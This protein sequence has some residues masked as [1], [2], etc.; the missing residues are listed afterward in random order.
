MGND[1]IRRFGL[2]GI[3]LVVVSML[4]VNVSAGVSFPNMIE[5]FP[6][7]SV[8]RTVILQNG[9]EGDGDVK[10]VMSISEGNEFVSVVDESEVVVSKGEPGYLPIRI[11]LPEG[12][13]VGDVHKVKLDFKAV[14]DATSEGSGNAVQFNVGYGMNFDIVSVPMVVEEVAP[15]SATTETPRKSSASEM[16]IW[17]I[18]VI[19]AFLISLWV[20]N[21][22]SGRRN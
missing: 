12:T 8:E 5:L 11:S 14:S 15:I 9:P 22:R 20:L 16:V 17:I 7:E 10:F 18:A 1:V 13:S 19:V 3:F 21:K 6:G 4:A 2:M